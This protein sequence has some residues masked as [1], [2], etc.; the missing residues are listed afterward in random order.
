M[1]W[2]VALGS[3]CNRGVP[4]A[5]QAPAANALMEVSDRFRRS[6][7]GFAIFNRRGA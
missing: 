3:L 5:A 7:N 1:R 2:A 6:D 4:R